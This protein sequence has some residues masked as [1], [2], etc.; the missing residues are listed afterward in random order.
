VVII[1]VSRNG[2]RLP[3]QFLFVFFGGFDVSGRVGFDGD[4]VDDGLVRVLGLK[5]F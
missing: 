3:Q 4:L 5:Q 1:A 2:P